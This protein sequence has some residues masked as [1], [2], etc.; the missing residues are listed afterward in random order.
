[1]LNL[2]HYKDLKGEYVIKV[3]DVDFNDDQL[4]ICE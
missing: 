2:R 3:G 4:R 1:M